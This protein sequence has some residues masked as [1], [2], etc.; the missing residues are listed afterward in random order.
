MKRFSSY[1][2]LV[3]DD[4]LDS[5]KGIVEY[6][7]IGFNTVFSANN[8]DEAKKVIQNDRVDIIFSDIRMPDG[9]GFMLIEWLRENGFDIPVVLISA[10]DDKEELFRA[11]RLGVVDYVVKPLSSDK[12]KTMLDLCYN[13]LKNSENIIYLAGGFFWEVKNSVLFKNNEPIKLT[14]NETKFFELMLQ[15]PGRAVSS[16]EIFYFLHD[17]LVKEYDSKSIRNIVYKLRK[18]LDDKLIENIYGGKY[19]VKIVK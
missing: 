1:F 18:K 13:R 17:G 11:I 7:Q 2:T 19:R 16:E 5:L 6:L 4:D 9:N 14:L 10:Y 3:V 8:I 12:L 15:Q